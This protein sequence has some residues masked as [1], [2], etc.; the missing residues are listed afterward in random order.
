MPRVSVVIHAHRAAE[1]Y[2]TLCE[3][4][5]AA[6]TPAGNE[7]EILIVEDD[8]T[9][10]SPLLQ[11]IA[12]A[13][14]EYVVVM[15]ADSFHPP[16]SIP[17]ML[18]LLE[19]KESDLVIGSRY[20]AGGRPDTK[21]SW[22]RRWIARLSLRLARPLGNVRDPMSGFLAFARR[23][24]PEAIDPSR[25]SS[26]LGLE[27]LVRGGFERVSEIPIDGSNGRR[28]ETEPWWRELLRDL[29][30]LNRLYHVRFRARYELLQ[31]GFIGGTGFLVDLAFYLGLQ[32]A[33]GLQHLV[34]RALSF[35]A[36]ATWNWV[37]NRKLTFAS[38]R[39][40]RKRIQ[41]PAFL[42][43]SLCGFALNWGTYYLLTTRFPFFADGG[44]RIL[45]LALGVLAG[46]G[47][48]FVLARAFV[49]LPHRTDGV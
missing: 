44:P 38:R 45:A 42:L 41:W 19:E 36:A 8:R 29:R 14:G 25:T 5:R 16:E 3:A 7:F 2:A 35:W 30:Q 48:N 43:S 26:A 4:V 33:F 37:W 28:S 18:R 31:F 21:R 9:S 40:T 15:D 6:L 34:A 1:S 22:F 11:G 32:T 13:R 17:S 20:A 39:R 24:V 47:V 46:M 10:A 12:D 27:L 23:G 49:F